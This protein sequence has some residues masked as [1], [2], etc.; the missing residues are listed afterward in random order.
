MRGLPAILI[1]NAICA[2]FTGHAVRERKLFDH[3]KVR[4]LN[5]VRQKIESFEADGESF[6]F[7]KPVFVVTRDVHPGSICYSRVLQKLG[8]ILITIFKVNLEV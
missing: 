6:T 7:A 3:I 1:V 8:E 5:A 2:Q 4:P